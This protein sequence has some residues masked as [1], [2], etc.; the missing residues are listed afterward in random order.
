MEANKKLSPI[1]TELFLR[2]RKLNISLVF[3]SQSY[4]KV[5]KIIRLNAP[6]YFIMKVSY[7]RELQQI[8]SNHSSEIDFKDYMKILKKHIHF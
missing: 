1:V 5:P 6:H 3:T 7:R 4:F 2:V 8:T